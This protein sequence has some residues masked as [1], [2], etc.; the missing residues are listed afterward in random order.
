MIEYIKD[1]WLTWRTGLTKQ[2]RVWH[3]W[4]DENIV[5]RAST[6]ENM[7]MHFKYILPVSTQIFA[8]GPFGWVS[9]PCTDFKQYCYPNRDLDNCA[10]YIFA[11]GYRDQWDGM[12]HLNDLRH[13]QDQV[14]VATNNEVDAMMITLK[15][16]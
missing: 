7:F 5:R 2:E 13:E 8:D 12:F 4:Q 6:I 1:K 11:R 9:L 15:Y 14:F 3:K 10:V 16:S